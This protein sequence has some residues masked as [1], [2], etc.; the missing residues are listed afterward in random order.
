M[1]RIGVFICHCGENI[2]ETVDCTKLAEV[3]SRF[4]GVVK[5]VDYKYMCSEPGQ[6][7]IKEAIKEN[8]LTGVVVAACSPRMHESTFR[9]TCSEAGL[10]PF[11][12]EIANLREHCSWVHEKSEEATNKAIDIVRALVEKVKL[13]EPLYPIKVPVT[14]TAL[15]IGGGVAGIQAALDIANGG[16]KVILVEKNPSIGGHMSQLSETF[17]TLDCSQCI[18]TPRMVEL[19]QHPNITLYSYAELESLDGFIGNFKVKIRKKAKSIDENL[20][21]GCGLCTTKCPVKKIPNEFDENLSYR[22]A[23]YV[24]FPQA[25]PNK[26]VIDRENCTYYLKGKCKICERFCPTQAIRFDQQDEIIEVE[27]GAIV[28]ATG[29]DIKR[30]D[31]FPEYGFGKYKDV[32]DGLQFERI[33]SASGPTLGEIRRLSDGKIPKKVVFIACAGSRDPAKGIEYCSKIC[34]MYTAKHAI[35]YKHKIHDGQ[36]YVFYM[37]IRA[38]GKNYDEFTRRAIEEEGAKYIRGRVS[39]IYE[40]DGKLI[41]VGADTL[42]NARPVVIEADMVVLATAGVASPGSEELAQKLHVAYDQYKFF[43]EAH[44]KL[45]PVET[46][47]AGI[48]LAGACQS[49]KDIPESVSQASGAAAKVCGLFS[50]NELTRDPLIAVVNRTAPPLYS[51]CVGCFLCQSVCPYQAIEKEEIKAKD[52][53]VIKIIAKINPG[54]CQGCGSCVALCRTKSIDLLGYTNRQ[55]YAE[56]DAILNTL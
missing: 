48:F 9:K 43:T 49:I 34:C 42:M 6:T 15:V 47:T 41:V 5:S 17:P 33:A 21:T 29:F 53:S 38:G 26:P 13:N 19:A 36:A 51:T 11:L 20:C 7:L 28:L 18:L 8:R 54:L 4:P 31:F 2:G 45:R 1:A 24:P 32:I 25:V 44:P 23:I 16:H 22:K 46:N 30:A 56:V 12:C 52:G 14:K 55:I 35:L 10:N 40:R 3:T 39:R 50:Q 37:D 27:A